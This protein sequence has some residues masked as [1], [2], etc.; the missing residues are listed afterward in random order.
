MPTIFLKI[1]RDQI[2]LLFFKPF[3]SRIKENWPAYLSW[4]LLITW[5]VG[6]GRYWDHP[7]ADWW[8]YLGLGSVA[9]VFILAVIIW[10]IAAPLKPRHWSYLNVLIFI[11]LTSL[12]ALLYAIP[13]EQFM[14]LQNAQSANF[15]FLLIVAA[16]RV[17]LFFN[18]LGKVA[19]LSLTEVIVTGLLPLVLI[20]TA[21]TVLNLEHV[22]FQIMGG[23]RNPT[24]ND[25]AYLALITIT[26]FSLLLSPVLLIWYG[27][28]I[29]KKNTSSSK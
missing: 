18:F 14:T 24:Q 16:W 13:V 2:A 22:V 10:I 7:N 17:A 4:G 19:G 27:F 9:Y 28:L 11:T 25:T 8:Q 3:K 23:I 12:P 6:M 1:L 5:I 21:L 15:W 26:Y 29:Y 20:V